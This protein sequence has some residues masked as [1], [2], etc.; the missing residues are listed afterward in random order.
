MEKELT[1]IY[2]T[3]EYELYD[4]WNAYMEEVGESLKEL[5]ERAEAPDATPEDLQKY[6]DALFEWT[7]NNQYYKDM[8]NEYT[9]RLA[10]VNE[11]ALSYVNDQLPKIYAVN[12]NQLAKD[13]STSHI[14]VSFSLVNEHTV[15]RLIT[16][17]K[18]KLYPKRIDIPKDKRWNRKNVQSQIMQGILQGE[19][20]PKIAARLQNVTSMNEAAAIRNART[21]T[22]C[23]EN[24]GIDDATDKA[25]EMGIVLERVWRATPDKR[26][27]AWHTKLDGQKRD[28]EGYFH[29]DFGK[30]RFPGDPEAHSCDRYN[31]RCRMVRE[32]IGFRNSDGTVTKI[33]D[34]E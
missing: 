33:S 7:T 3:A 22:T 27:R 28:K 6:K 32:L 14:N 15:K 13:L 19:S 11:I 25:E 30:I 23:A 17:K 29:S 24:M 26:T 2:Q 20:I 16:D 21:M 10:H 31:C 34:F 18:V 5:R 4:K 1:E 9:T 12:Y 8:V